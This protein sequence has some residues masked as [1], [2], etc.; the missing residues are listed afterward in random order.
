MWDRIKKGAIWALNGIA[1]A[2]IVAGLYLGGERMGW[3]G[4][5]PTAA[6]PDAAAM[7]NRLSGQVAEHEAQLEATS[8]KLADVEKT[9]GAAGEAAKKFAEALATLQAGHAD[10]ERRILALEAGTK[11]SAPAPQAP[12]AAVPAPAAPAISSASSSVATK[13]DVEA[14][15]TKVDSVNRRIDRVVE[16]VVEDRRV[17]GEAFAAI[18]KGEKAPA[19]RPT[20]PAVKSATDAANY[21]RD[22]SGPSDPRYFEDTS[23]PTDPRYFQ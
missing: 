1:V 8:A 15:A 4:E 19:K 9:L 2:G 7:V 16:V 20:R 14:V 21:F 23:G 3:W 11:A 13:A 10:Q 5:K 18:A 6:N 22:N 12:T 17:V